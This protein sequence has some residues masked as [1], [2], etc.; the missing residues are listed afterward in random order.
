MS[1]KNGGVNS[2][3]LAEIMK[4]GKRTLERELSLLRKA[5]IV[6]RIGSDKTGHWE[7]VE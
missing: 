4:L 6:R 3:S 1:Q 5:N 2:H 7:V